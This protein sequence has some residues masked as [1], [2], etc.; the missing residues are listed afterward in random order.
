MENPQYLVI[1]TAI[2]ETITHLEDG[3]SRQDVGAVAG[4]MATALSRHQCD[5]TLLTSTGQDEQG[6]K[7][8]ER[9]TEAGVKTYTVTHT[10]KTGWASISTR[11][12]EQARTQGA[13]PTLDE[14][15][16]ELAGNLRDIDWILVDCNLSA[17]ALNRI[18]GMAAKE[19]IPVTINAT[20]K[21]KSRLIWETRTHPK[22]LATMNRD[23]QLNLMRL[24]DSKT[25]PELR[26]NLNSRNVFVSS[27]PQGWRV[28]G[29]KGI[30]ASSTAI[31][32]PTDTDYIGCGDYATAGLTH[33]INAGLPIV[34]T[35]NRFIETRLQL[36][37]I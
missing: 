22:R 8:L 12:G 2:T 19:Q 4:Q 9:L 13:W 5:V 23:E 7:T 26:E 11:A 29:A 15:A 35:V 10:S 18:L 21:G 27:G 1:G 32:T 28:D 20:T 31:P 36:N 14:I 6:K 17:T 3:K 24:S 34:E 37:T 16:S 33:A 30:H 25:V